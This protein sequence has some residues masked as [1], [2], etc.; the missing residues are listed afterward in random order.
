MEPKS[1]LIHRAVVFLSL[2][3]VLSGFAL[4]ALAQEAGS[5]SAKNW[6]KK[7]Y[8]TFKLGGFFPSLSANIRVDGPGGSQG[9]DINVE[10]DFGLDKNATTFRLDGDL[11]IASWFSLGL[12][13]YGFSRSSTKAL[14]KNIQIGDTLFPLHQTV[15]TTMTTIFGNV[16][17]KFY[18]IHRQRLDFGV[19]A[20]IY[21][22]HLKIDV[23]A[24]EIDRQ[25]I[26]IRKIWAP[27]PSIG[28]HFWYEPVPKLFLYGKAGYFYLEP[29]QRTKFDSAT[30][31]F[32]AEYYFYKF[33]GIGARYEYSAMNLNLD[34]SSYRG[35]LNYNVSGF[36]AYLAL[37]F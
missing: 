7:P 16:D 28:L 11:R 35:K 6:K 17:L 5:A 29:T 37:G 20:G 4:T 19:Y 32:N 2:S 15:K 31:N 1:R 26:A 24:Q 8:F 30:I 13:Y 33:L 14:D 9:T 36:Q 34:V 12:N 18:L 25:L 21:L 3:L 22:T 27:I 23:R 10:N